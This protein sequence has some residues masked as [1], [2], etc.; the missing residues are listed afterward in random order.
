MWG[1]QFQQWGRQSDHPFVETYGDSIFVVWQN[2]AEEE[3]YKGARHVGVFP[4][5]FIWGNHSLTPTISLYPVNASGMV[6]TFVDKSSALSEYDI[7][8]KTAP[9]APLHNLSNTPHTKSL[10]PHTSLK[11]TVDPPTQY[12]VWQEGNDVPY[13]IKFERASTGRES[14]SVSA[15]FNSIAGFETPSM[16]IVERDTFIS[17]WQIPVDIGDNTL[18]YE[19]PLELDYTYKA[20]I[21]A[22]H[23]AQG[24][25]QAG[26]RLDG[27]V[28]GVIQYNAFQPETL[29]ILV[30]PALYQDSLL[31]VEFELVSGGLAMGPV[32]IY[33]Y[34]DEPG[35]RYSGGPQSAGTAPLSG[36]T[37]NLCN[38]FKGDVRIDFTLPF[39]QKTEVSLY[40]AAGR[41]LKKM[42]VA[43]RV[44]ITEK[45]L[46][47][48][49][50]FLRV[51]NPI[52]GDAACWKFVKMK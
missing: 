32:H 12:T 39:D 28:S 45:N 51:D 15:Y 14:P 24:P 21:I 49:V 17:D 18:K 50:Y 3:V 22:Y 7:F 36:L 26:V 9:G 43:K 19:F 4:P 29:E 34:E 10:F 16:Y 11:V 44:L 23:E 27:S 35:G 42:K 20:K 6:T 5:R 2:E 13:E 33:R 47:A 40:D 8:W 41:V 1:W 30:P 38:M 25:W 37:I 46:A 48:G 31:E 52:T